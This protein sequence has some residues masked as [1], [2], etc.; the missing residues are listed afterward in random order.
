MDKSGGKDHRPGKNRASKTPATR[1]INA[2]DHPYPLIC[3][4]TLE[5]EKISRTAGRSGRERLALLERSFLQLGIFHLQCEPS[6][7]KVHAGSTGG[8]GGAPRARGGLPP[9][10][11]R[12]GGGGKI[13]SP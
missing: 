8:R 9:P 5:T 2:G 11:C 7:R 10:S 4:E 12:G 13:V 3:Q 1:L 6:F